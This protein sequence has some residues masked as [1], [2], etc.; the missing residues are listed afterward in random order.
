MGS[1]ANTSLTNLKKCN[2]QF[3]CEMHLEIAKSDECHIHG[4]FAD[5]EKHQ[6]TAEN[7]TTCD[8]ELL[9]DEEDKTWKA[10]VIP[11]LITVEFESTDKGE[12]KYK[13]IDPNLE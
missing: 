1:M 6:I 13:V 10:Q 5:K 3:K 8:V 9:H 12:A 7:A 2:I 11:S 4:P